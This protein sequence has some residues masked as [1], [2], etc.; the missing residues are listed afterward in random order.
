MASI[1]TN[2]NPRESV[3]NIG[4]LFEFFIIKN[5]L[6]NPSAARGQRTED[7]NW[8][9]KPIPDFDAPAFDLSSGQKQLVA[10][11]NLRTLN[12]WTSKPYRVKILM[13]FKILADIED[14]AEGQSLLWTNFPKHLMI[15]RADSWKPCPQAACRVQ[16]GE[17]EQISANRPSPEV[18]A[19]WHSPFGQPVDGLISGLLRTDC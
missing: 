7:K 8:K 11:W 15:N 16:R 2:S 18:H 14:R 9:M 1:F 12:L 4:I 5:Q 17:H 3:L 6:V 19:G 13:F 10:G